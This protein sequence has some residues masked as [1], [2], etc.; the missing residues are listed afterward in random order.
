MT[1][2]ATDNVRSIQGEQT[3]RAETVWLTPMEVDQYVDDQDDD[4]LE[5]RMSMR[6]DFPK[7]RRGQSPPFTG[8]SPEG[9]LVARMLCRRC[10]MAVRVEQW[11]GERRGN[12]TRYYVHSRHLEYVK[13]PEG[14]T[15]SAKTGGRMT[16]RQIEESVMTAAVK[17]AGLTLTDLRK[18]AKAS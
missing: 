4:V 8:V 15:Y 12:E 5:C 14:K 9:M 3:E 16:P 17:G 18:A 11:Q 7:P 10:K 13:N 6:H 2:E 1:D